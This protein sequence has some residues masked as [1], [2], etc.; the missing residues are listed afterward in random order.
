MALTLREGHIE[1]RLE[2]RM[3]LEQLRVAGKAGVSDHQAPG[4]GSGRV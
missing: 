2:A 1:T 3:E 4:L